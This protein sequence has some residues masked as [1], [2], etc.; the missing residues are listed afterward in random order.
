MKSLAEEK[1]CYKT[2]LSILEQENK[3]KTESLKKLEL[4]VK[5]LNAEVEKKTSYIKTQ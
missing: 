2:Q 3:N 1:E 4:K 5:Q